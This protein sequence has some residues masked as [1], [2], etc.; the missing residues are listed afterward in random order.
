M[1]VLG[2]P[3]AFILSQDQTL[4]KSLFPNQF[5]FWL[6]VHLMVMTLSCHLTNK[7][8]FRFRNILMSISKCI[9]SFRILIRNVRGWLYYSFIKVRFALFALASS[10][11]LVYPIT[12]VLC[13]QHYFFKNFKLFLF[14]FFCIFFPLYMVFISAFM[15]QLFR[16]LLVR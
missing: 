6:F 10:A 3:P 4:K 9:S 1:H 11:R 15:T 13:C 14:Y 2:T 7:G 12:L 8:L 16:N 5:Y